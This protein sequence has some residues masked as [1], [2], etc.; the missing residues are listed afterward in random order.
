MER[1]VFWWHKP[2]LP[3]LKDLAEFEDLDGI[4]I[5]APASVQEIIEWQDR[6]GRDAA[7][8]HHISFADADLQRRWL[9]LASPDEYVENVMSWEA[10]ISDDAESDGQF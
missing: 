9:L 5:D 10:G 8:K 2:A 6:F 1:Q 7:E 3:E 4:L